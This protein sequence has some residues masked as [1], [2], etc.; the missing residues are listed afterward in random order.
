MPPP[1]CTCFTSVFTGITRMLIRRVHILY[2]WS[3]CML[4]Q[5]QLLCCICSV[6]SIKGYY[7]ISLYNTVKLLKKHLTLMNTLKVPFQALPN[8][9]T[10]F[11]V[12]KRSPL[13]YAGVFG[14]ICKWMRGTKFSSAANPTVKVYSPYV[15]YE[16]N[17][18][19]RLDMTGGIF[20]EH[21]KSWWFVVCNWDA[22]G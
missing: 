15:G 20:S 7:N 19:C 11:C 3:Y 5:M 16:S 13:F 12:K 22:L 18:L 2:V 6:K 14:L 10:S 8:N 9:H 1:Y 4:L 17:I 21:Q